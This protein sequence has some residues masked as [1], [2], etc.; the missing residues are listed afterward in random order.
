MAGMEITGVGTVGTEI[1]GDGTIG[2][3]MAGMVV[4]TALTGVT[5]FTAVIMV[6]TMVTVGT[7]DIMV[8]E[9]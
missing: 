5:D 6:D 3:G 9:M 1:A 4:I 7:M 8:V 2:D